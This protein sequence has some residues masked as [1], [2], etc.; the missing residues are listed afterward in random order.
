[1]T[2]KVFAGVEF[3]IGDTNPADIFTPEEFTEEHKLIKET[4]RDFVVNDVKPKL[5]EVDEKKEGVAM[6]LFAKA[7]ELGLLGTDVP[8]EYGG[9]GLDK[10]STTIV[11]ECFGDAGSIAG[12]HGAHTGIG[13]LPIIWFG[14]EEHKQKYLPKLATGE[15]V[16]AYCLTESGSGSDAL[17]AKAK[18]V[19]SEDG[20]HYILNGEKVFITN[21]G[22]AK[23]FVVYAKVDGDKFTGFLVEAGTPGLSTG[24]EEEKLG[25]HGSSTRSVILEDVKVPVENVLYEVGQGHKIAFNVLNIGRWKLGAGSLGGAKGAINGSIE[26]AKQRI[27]FGKPISSFGMIRAKLADMTA[28]TY[29]V[30]S[31]VYRLAAMLDDRLATL[32]PEDKK[33]GEKLAKAVEEYAVECSIA[34]IMGSEVLHFCCDEYVQILGGYGYITEYP[35]ERYYR[36]CRIN[37]IWEG[38]NEINRMLIPGTIMK[39]AMQGRVNLLGAAQAVGKELIE[40]SPMG[41]SIPEGPLGLQTHCVKMM[42]KIALMISGLAAQ[43][44]GMKLSEE[45]E[46]LAGLADTVMDIYA[47]E[48]AVLRTQKIIDTMG[49]NKAAGQIAATELFVDTA[50]PMLELR[51]KKLLTHMEKGDM[52]KTQLAGLRKLAKYQPIDS[53]ERAGIVADLVTERECYPF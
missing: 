47:C 50:M 14:S 31:L 43:K 41:V 51:A 7:G 26:Y 15:W 23:T 44:Y 9:L 27:Q 3:L 24:R 52:L 10:V 40:F 45:Q 11:T 33:Q 16:G 46:I 22:W 28:R 4:A 30:E 36:D 21:A 20:K 18:A 8:E 37:R 35:A 29:A 34:K 53:I 39:R 17:A 48:S 13:T 38:T 25:M 49:A 42:K 6:G 19:L 2:R 12:L 1:M 32:S 5:P